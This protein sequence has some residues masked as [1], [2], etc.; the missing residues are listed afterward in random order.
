M[1]ANEKSGK[2]TTT[3]PGTVENWEGGVLG[4]SLDF[5][6]KS[7]LTIDDV[8][9]AIGLKLISIRMPEQMIEDLKLLAKSDGIGS[10]QTLIKQI[11]ARFIDCELKNRARK[12]MD[13][14]LSDQSP[15]DKDP[16]KTN[17]KPQ[18]AAC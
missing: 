10:Y 4:N 17:T 3:I 14:E 12:A 1:A 6:K 18:K 8:Q 13:D 16:P 2:G 9:D 11:L 5:A 15:D 7:S